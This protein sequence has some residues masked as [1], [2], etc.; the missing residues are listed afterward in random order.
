VIAIVI[1]VAAVARCVNA[2]LSLTTDHPTGSSL[3]VAPG[4]TSGGSR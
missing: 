1:S 4:G 3:V 2:Q